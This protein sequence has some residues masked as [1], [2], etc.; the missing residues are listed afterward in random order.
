G[1]L[2][3]APG[4][5]SE[6]FTITSD[7]ETA[8][9][10]YTFSNITNTQVSIN[11]LK[12]G[13]NGTVLDGVALQLAGDFVNLKT[14][15]TT[16][17]TVTWDSTSSAKNFNNVVVSTS[18]ETH[19]YTLTETARK[20]G[21]EAFTGSVTFTVDTEGKIQLV[22]NPTLSDGAAA[23]SVSDDNL[24]LTLRNIKIGGN[25]KLKKVDSVTGD[26]L[27]GVVF[28][29]YKKV[30]AAVD[31]DNDVLIQDNLTTDSNGE[32]STQ[33]LEE[34]NYYFVEKSTLDNYVFDATPHEFS[35]GA[36]DNDQTIDIGNVN[37]TPLV[38]TVNVGKID[39]HTG[40]DLSGAQFTLYKQAAGGAWETYGTPKTTGADGQVSFTINHKGTYKVAET[41]APANFVVADWVSDVFTIDNTST[42]QN[43]TQTFGPVANVRK[44]GSATVQK[45]DALTGEALAGVEFTLTNNHGCVAPVTAVTNA[46]GVATFE[47]LTFMDSY[48]IT[49]TGTLDTYILSSRSET[50][51]LTDAQVNVTF[52]GWQNSPTEF[53]FKKIQATPNPETGE[54]D[55]LPGATFAIYATEDGE[56]TGDALDTQKSDEN[57]IVTFR[58]LKKGATYRVEETEAPTDYFLNLTSFTVIVSEDGKTITMSDAD[59]TVTEVPNDEMGDITLNK[60]DEKDQVTPL[61]GA[62]FDLYATDEAGE[63]TE[64]IDTQTTDENGVLT[65]SELHLG[66]YVIVENEPAEGYMITD[67]ETK[68]TL[69]KGT[70]TQHITVKRTNG[71]PDFNFS[72]NVLYLEGCYAPD[73]T[74]MLGGV[75]FGL[76]EDAECATRPE[77]LAVS[78]ESGNVKFEY[79]TVQTWYMKETAVPVND[80]GVV[81][82]ETIYEVV[83]NKDGTTTIDAVSAPEVIITNDVA[84]TKIVLKKTEEGKTNVFLPGAKF[85]LYRTLSDDE[86][87]ARL[88]DEEVKGITSSENEVLVAEAVTDKDGVVTFEDVLT[89]VDYIIRELEAPAGYELTKES[90]QIEFAYDAESGAIAVKSFK[91]GNGV[92][93]MDDEGNIIWNDPP[94]KIAIIKKDEAGNALAGATLRILNED[95]TRVEGVEDWVSGNEAH[96]V[97]GLL[98]RGKTYILMEVSAPNGYYLADPVKFT[99]TTDKIGVNADY[100]QTVTMVDKKIPPKKTPK[101]GDNG[102]AG[103][104]VALL[105][106][107]GGAAGIVFRRKKKQAK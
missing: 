13:E 85:G 21:Y 45:V 32:V 3:G 2:I 68:V 11:I 104:W 60:V 63:K 51:T 61:A 47:G 86:L 80:A 88:A 99:L 56:K 66:T 84:R 23:A 91:D 98:V 29:V 44:T 71:K 34:G 77:Y 24:T 31:A 8:T 105:A 22:S 1:W 103:L 73:A 107:S 39:S 95:G 16:A 74:Q 49:E 9:L 59:G 83:V 57:G 106:V 17:G 27:Q 43:G 5:V 93:K 19:T 79:V 18:S 65:F 48:T 12:T 20:S 97:D 50:F 81:L 55:P 42:Y 94:T 87:A 54:N 90:A 72:K 26:A 100:V 76:F 28:Q 102:M 89:S 36:D 15:V 46:N 70:A 78:D 6:T 30:G 58:Y 33:N 62:I 52:T 40:A 10:E 38:Y 82:D 37:N 75:Q 41:Q 92:A 53:K 14:G 67:T 4:S 35:I 7:A 69:E 101:T 96:R 64:V 25:A